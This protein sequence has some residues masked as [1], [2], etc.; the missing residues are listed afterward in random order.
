MEIFLFLGLYGMILVIRGEIMLHSEKY[1]NEDGT[2]YVKPQIDKKKYMKIGAVLLIILFVVLVFWNL[3]SKATKN[4]A[5]NKMED[6]LLEAGYQYASA[7]KILP[8]IEGEAVTISSKKLLDGKY[9][10]E[11]DLTYKETQGTAT[12]TITKYKD[13]YIKSVEVEN[14]GYCSERYKGWG[15]ETT[16]YNPKKRAVKVKAMYN[17]YDKET[18]YTQYTEYLESSMVSKKKSKYGT[19][20]PK[21]EDYLPEVPSPGIIVSIE[22]EQK[23]Y[24][25]YR[26]KM[27]RYYANQCN[28]SAYSAEKPAGYAEKDTNTYKESEW[29]KWSINYPD[30][31]EYRVID[32]TSGY[33]WYYKDGRKKVY[34]N[35]GEYLP[36]QPNKKYPLRDSKE[37]SMYRYR[38]EL[39][40]WKNGCDRDYTSLTSETYEGYPYRDEETLEYT[41]WSYWEPESYVDSSN[42]YYREQR[43]DMH[44]RY[45]IKYDI[46]S[47]IKLDQAVTKE[48][49]EK[50]LGR[51]LEEIVKDPKIAL[52]VTYTF[53]YKK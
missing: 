28:Y 37:V 30:E 42:S 27:W 26:D 13:E 34:Y 32:Q 35:S 20:L 31:K 16:T 8:K 18:Y 39:Y 44:S 2:P 4:G 25:E 5:C 15:K 11:E 53:Q 43:V 48:A 24:Y 22:Q 33:R 9:I 7:K 47:L 21:D 40:R 50:Q 38:D 17:Y 52:E 45:R 3:I 36:E 29:S 14:C 6:K 23:P 51:P 12:I 46:Y 1:V 49:F 10:T 41:S 19:Y